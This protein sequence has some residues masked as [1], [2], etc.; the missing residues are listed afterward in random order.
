MIL[1]IALVAAGVLVISVPVGWALGRW[2]SMRWTLALA[3]LG[4][5]VA[6]ILLALVGTMEFRDS[7][8]ALLVGG[9]IAAPLALGLVLGVGLAAATRR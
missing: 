1:G 8:N 9:G 3:A 5:L 2:V 4:A 7:M 6:A